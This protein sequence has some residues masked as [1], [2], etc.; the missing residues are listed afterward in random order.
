MQ[1]SLMPSVVV[2]DENVKKGALKADNMKSSLNIV[3]A[4][5]TPVKREI[6]PVLQNYV[7]VLNSDKEHLSPIHPG[8]ARRLLKERKAAI[9]RRYPFTVIL[10]ENLQQDVEP[11]ILKIDPGSKFTGL[12]LLEERLNRVIWAGVLQ[13]RQ[14][15]IKLDLLKR[16]GCRKDR[17]SHKTRYRKCRRENRVR[18]K[19][20]FYPSV[21]HIYKTL[22]TWVKRLNTLTKISSISIEQVK[23][24][25]Q[26]IKN[27]YIKGT[28]YQQGPLSKFNEKEY[29]LRKHNKTCFYCG[30]SEGVFQ[31]DHFLSKSKG[32]TDKISNLVLSCVSCNQKKGSN[33]VLSAKEN[34][35]FRESG[36]VNS[37]RKKLVDVVTSFNKPLEIGIGIQTREN[38]L[39]LNLPKQHWIDAALVGDSGVSVIVNPCMKFLKIKSMGHGNRQ[40]CQTDK[41]GFPK[42][43]KTCPKSLFGFQTGDFVKAFTKKGKY[44]GKHMGRITLH[45][46][47]RFE[48]RHGKTIVRA[49][50]ETCVLLQK[51]DGYFYE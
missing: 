51:K 48:V 4:N 49:K 24:D 20:S 34:Y 22:F 25:N 42:N 1:A 39:A 30:T 14:L 7:F 11:L 26:K 37:L 27:P 12:A 50:H 47:G 44:P 9:F 36:V 35:L 41:Y 18:S 16:K 10:K 23:F 46:D 8:E 45:M 21:A 31:K 19:N 32:G 29:L 28:Q 13:H 38:R 3:E 43:I 17:R 15:E 5:L 40:Q 33:Q 6:R 2:G